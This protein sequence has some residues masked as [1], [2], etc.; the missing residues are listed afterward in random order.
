MDS[1]KIKKKGK[2]RRSKQPKL[3]DMYSK[4]FFIHSEPSEI[5]NLEDL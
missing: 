4:N 2:K 5:R 3:D 1:K